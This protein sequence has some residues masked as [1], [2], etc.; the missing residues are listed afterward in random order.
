ML[1]ESQLEVKFGGRRT[2]EFNGLDKLTRRNALSQKIEPE[3]FCGQRKHIYT[4][5]SL[6]EINFCIAVTPWY[7][8]NQSKF[9]SEVGKVKKN[10]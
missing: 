4:K 10:P 7:S 9:D 1:S 8:F 5:C 2:M 6:R 3:L